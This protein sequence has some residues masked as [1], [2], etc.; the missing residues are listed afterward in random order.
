V[1]QLF[2]PENL[3]RYDGHLDRKLEGMLG[4]PVRPRELLS[5]LIRQRYPEHSEP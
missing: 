5:R 3:G 1:G 4:M 2:E